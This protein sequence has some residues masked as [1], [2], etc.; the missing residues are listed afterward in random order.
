MTWTL[1]E[2]PDIGF[3]GVIF[4]PAQNWSEARLAV[5]NGTHRWCGC[6]GGILALKPKMDY[7]LKP[8]E[9][10]LIEVAP[11]HWERDD[12][13]QARGPA[14]VPNPAD[15]LWVRDFHSG[16]WHRSI[17]V[18][19][20]EVACKKSIPGSP[21]IIRRGDPSQPDERDQCP[22]CAAI[23]CPLCDETGIR[24][25]GCGLAE[26]GCGKYQQN[27][28]QARR[29]D[30][31]LAAREQRCV[32]DGRREQPPVPGPVRAQ[33]HGGLGAVEGDEIIRNLPPIPRVA[34]DWF[35]IP[36]S[37]NDPQLAEQWIRTAYCG[38]RVVRLAIG[39][40][41]TTDPRAVLESNPHARKKGWVATWASPD[42]PET[43]FTA[44]CHEK[45]APEAFRAACDA[46]RAD[47]WLLGGPDVPEPWT[48][49]KP[50]P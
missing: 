5:H 20:M 29:N 49:D 18:D 31:V 27:M 32:P 4:G 22:S 12:P 41:W 47:G 36:A 9:H 37:P 17:H 38:T 2:T 43:G 3:T 24:E 8:H 10:W 19:G 23:V 48:L 25:V 50:E 44:C 46:L 6:Q 34:S 14:T 33:L 15:V 35:R 39:P 16:Q 42:H 11:I 40:R 21:L 45:T 7:E 1:T 28:S 13:L 26:C 30:A